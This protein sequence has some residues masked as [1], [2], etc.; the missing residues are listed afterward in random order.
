MRWGVGP[1]MML[2]LGAAVHVPF[3]KLEIVTM[4]R[5]MQAFPATPPEINRAPVENNVPKAPLMTTYVPRKQ[6]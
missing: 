3:F 1:A 2:L 4:D 5:S 6:G